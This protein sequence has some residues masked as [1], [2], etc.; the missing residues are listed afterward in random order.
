M[1]RA[2]LFAHLTL[3]AAR[4]FSNC[5]LARESPHHLHERFHP[6]RWRHDLHFL[7]VSLQVGKR[8][9]K[10]GL[11]PG[12]ALAAMGKA[13]GEVIRVLVEQ[14]R[15]RFLVAG[16]GDEAVRGSIVV[17][18]VL[19]QAQAPGW[20]HI[21]AQPAVRAPTVVDLR[22]FIGR[23]PLG[24]SLDPGQVHHL[25]R[26]A[27]AD[28]GAIATSD[29]LFEVVFVKPAVAGRDFPLLVRIRHGARLLEQV[30]Q[31]YERPKNA[32]LAH[33]PSF[34]DRSPARRY[35]SSIPHGQCPAPSF[36]A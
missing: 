28:V 23:A 18:E 13:G 3:E 1:C 31:R 6:L 27:R 8:E 26:V 19:R 35:S 32:S 30:L 7:G 9:L 29:A 14:F 24:V 34:T 12:I 11:V 16:D 20:A 5:L 21:D 4:R 22:P 15:G 17:N 33:L 2:C 10:L 36:P 25:D